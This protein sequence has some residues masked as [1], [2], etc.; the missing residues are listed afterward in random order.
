MA[1][2]FN[3]DSE[4]FW[5][6]GRRE[7]DRVSVLEGYRRQIQA[8]LGNWY[9]LPTNRPSLVSTSLNDQSDNDEHL[10]IILLCDYYVP[11]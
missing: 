7:T 6:S 2:G 10:E 5:P 3:T 8:T 4:M 11:I 9:V 1:I